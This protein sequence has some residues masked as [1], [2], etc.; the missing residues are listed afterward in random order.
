MEGNKKLTKGK[1]YF[2]YSFFKANKKM[3]VA[4]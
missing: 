1:L 4:A 2:F 3:L